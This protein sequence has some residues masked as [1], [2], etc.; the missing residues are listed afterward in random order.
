MIEK[1]LIINCIHNK[2]SLSWPRNLLYSLFL[3]TGIKL[4]ICMI[5]KAGLSTT[6]IIKFLSLGPVTSCIVCSWVQG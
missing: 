4:T 1:A 2:F 6:Y 5:E 3:G